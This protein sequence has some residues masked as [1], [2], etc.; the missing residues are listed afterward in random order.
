MQLALQQAALEFCLPWTVACLSYYQS[1]SLFARL[2]QQ[3]TC[4]DPNAHQASENEELLASP[5]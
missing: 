1:F 2:N 4:Q 3:M 5:G